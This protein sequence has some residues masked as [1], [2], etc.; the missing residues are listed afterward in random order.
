[1]KELNVMVRD[2]RDARVVE[3]VI[4]LTEREMFLNKDG[5]K[6]RDLIKD[7]LALA[8]KL[9]WEELM[10]NPELESIIRRLVINGS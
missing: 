5:T 2:P 8:E 7:K 10:K 6:L 4:W 3:A 1:V 9:I